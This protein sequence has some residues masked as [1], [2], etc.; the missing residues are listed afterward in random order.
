M[1]IALN[2]GT[3]ERIQLIIIIGGGRAACVI[4]SHI[5]C[6]LPHTHFLHHKYKNNFVSNIFPLG[7]PFQMRG[8]G[9]RL[10]QWGFSNRFSYFYGS[11][12]LIILKWEVLEPPNPLPTPLKLLY[13]SQLAT[14]ECTFLGNLRT[15]ILQY[16]LCI[17]Q[18]K[19]L[20]KFNIILYS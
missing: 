13:V 9:S 12:L 15:V 2:N 18:F 6:G 5:F 17:R 1:A 7:S 14:Y 3:G 4:L 20:L 16:F 11:L 10:S 8:G 19:L